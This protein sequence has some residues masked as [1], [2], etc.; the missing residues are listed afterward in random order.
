VSLSG[1]Y[2]QKIDPA[3]IASQHGFRDAA[4]AERFLVQLLVQ[5]DLPASTRESLSKDLSAAGGLPARLRRLTHRIA[6]LPEYQLA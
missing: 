5:D 3:A 2:G 4:A 1:P 6:S